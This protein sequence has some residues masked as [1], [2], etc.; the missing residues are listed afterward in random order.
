MLVS[1]TNNQRF[2]W[3]VVCWGYTGADMT[4]M[5]G[6]TIKCY[7]WDSFLELSSNT[8]DA[9]IEQ[10]L[11]DQRPGHCC[12]LIYTSGTTGNPKVACVLFVPLVI[13]A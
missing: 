11:A 8:A 7:T 1:N 6:K 13:P 9:V 12:A 3:Q 5:D 2:V 4:G 10:R